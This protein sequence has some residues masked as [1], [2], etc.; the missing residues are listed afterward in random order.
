MQAHYRDLVTSHMQCSMAETVTST[1]NNCS[2]AHGVNTDEI[3][4]LLRTLEKWK[5]ECYSTY[6]LLENC[7]KTGNVY[8]HLKIFVDS[9][10][11]NQLTSVVAIWYQDFHPAERWYYVFTTDTDKLNILI[12]KPGVFSMERSA[13]VR[14]ACEKEAAT[15][16]MKDLIITEMGWQPQDIYDFHTY[17]NT[18]VELTNKTADRP[19]PADFK[20]A[21][22]ETKYAEMVRA[23]WEPGQTQGLE[24]FENSIKY[25]PNLAIYNKEG[26][27]I[28]WVFVK[29]HGDIGMTYTTPGYQRRGF[30]SILTAKLSKMLLQEGEIPFIKIE[31]DNEIS[32]DMHTKLGFQ[33]YSDLT[34]FYF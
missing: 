11:L 27:P 17:T 14:V 1:T 28:S 32:T 10:D 7:H 24:R 6:K 30:A 2:E 34:W 29:E 21:P 12:R 31:T 22:L 23:S 20:I 25:Q 19:I 8:P 13:K 16:V 4:T 33:R 15:L 5:M 26:V 9:G 3:P 18:N